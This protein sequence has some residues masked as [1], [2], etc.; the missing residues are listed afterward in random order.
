M[1]WKQAEG[2]KIGEL[3]LELHSPP[4]KDRVI[5]YDARVEVEGQTSRFDLARYHTHL[6]W[7]EAFGLP[8]F[9]EWV[10][11]KDL[12]ELEGSFTGEINGEKY[13]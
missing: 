8:P 1:G 12:E 7:I 2:E 9:N 10:V 13:G 5:W 4:V 3:E 11:L 6:G